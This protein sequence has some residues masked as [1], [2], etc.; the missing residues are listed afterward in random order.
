[1][2]HIASTYLTSIDILFAYFKPLQAVC[3][4]GL[5]Y[6]DFSKDSLR[7]RLQPLQIPNPTTSFKGDPTQHATFTEEQVELQQ[8]IN[9]I[10]IFT[11][12]CPGVTTPK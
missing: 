10:S 2:G 5:L 6:H 12:H 8:L 1:M 3:L 4:W 11:S 9:A 7:S